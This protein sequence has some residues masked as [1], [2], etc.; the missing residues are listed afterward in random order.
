MEIIIHNQRIFFFKKCKQFSLF[1]FNKY[2]LKATLPKMSTLTGN[3]STRKCPNFKI[4]NNKGNKHPGLTDHWSENSCPKHPLNIAQAK[5]TAQVK[6]TAEGQSTAHG[7][8]LAKGQSTL[9][10]KILEQSES[11]SQDKCSSS[12]KDG[13]K[14]IQFLWFKNLKVST[15]FIHI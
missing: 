6:N 7:K 4:C 3:Y 11:T 14:C 5:S 12:I 15:F 2:V 10:D 13:Y 1:L 9:Q 8:S